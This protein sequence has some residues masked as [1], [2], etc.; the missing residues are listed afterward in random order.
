MLKL[1]IIIIRHR[2]LSHISKAKFSGIVINKMIENSAQTST[3]KLS[4]VLCVACISGKQARLPFN[5]LKNE[6]HVRQL[7]LIVQTDVR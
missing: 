3:I 2:R 6:K 4:D 7:L 5:K 1:I